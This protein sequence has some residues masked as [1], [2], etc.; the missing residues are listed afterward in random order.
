MAIRRNVQD[1]LAGIAARTNSSGTVVY[2]G[3]VQ[4]DGTI[5]IT[6]NGVTY[7]PRVLWNDGPAS[8]TNDATGVGQ[9]DSVTILNAD[10]NISKGDTQ[11]FLQTLV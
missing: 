2:V 8:A 9:A 6:R 10:G 11:Q 3:T 5:Q 7:C 1:F 4:K